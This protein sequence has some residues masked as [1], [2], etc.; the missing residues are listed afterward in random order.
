MAD[1]LAVAALVRKRAELAGRIAH[2]RRELEGMP[3]GPAAL[4]ATL[5]LFDPG[6]LMPPHVGSAFRI[7]AL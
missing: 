2:A 6:I 4:D 3:T 5:R 1:E 7:P